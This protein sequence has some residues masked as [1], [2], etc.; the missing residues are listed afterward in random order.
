[1]SY[2]CILIYGVDLWVF[3]GKNIKY[4][5]IKEDLIMIDCS[6]DTL[7]NLKIK[8]IKIFVSHSGEDK[9]IIETIKS[10]LAQNGYLPYVAERKSIGRPLTSKLREELLDSNSVLV[11][12]T[13][14]AKDRSNEIIGFEAGMAWANNIPIFILKDQSANFNK[15]SWFYPQLTDYV[16]IE[17]FD[18]ENLL[19][20][21]INEFDFLKYHNPICFCFPK[22]DSPKQNCENEIVVWSDGSIHLWSEFKGRIHFVIGN[23]TNKIIRDSRFTLE[24]P[25]YI[26]I[27][28][29]IEDTDVQKNEMINMKLIKSAIVRLMWVALPS[30]EHWSHELNLTVPKIQQETK[31]NIYIKIQ[32]G[33]YSKK[34]IDV[35]LITH[36]NRITES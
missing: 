31:G 2:Y 30:G 5:P 23:H 3:K 10:I 33:E 8:P 24:F 17:N 4:K 11:V 34:E 18:D 26:K 35:P 19:K 25:D 16:G 20:G 9:S 12:W 13:K 32:G 29:N 14:N 28:F 27:D 15:N 6:I 7:S 22:Q 36:T 21:K 1:M